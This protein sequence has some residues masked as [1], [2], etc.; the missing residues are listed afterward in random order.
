MYIIDGIAYAGEMEKPIKLVSVRPMEEY[1]LW[2]RFSND[3]I[4]MFDVKPLLKFPAFQR[5]MDK[6]I[7]NSVYI[8][9]GIPTWCDGEIDYCPDTLYSQSNPVNFTE[10]IEVQT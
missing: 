1:N 5:L 6:D 3:E 10:Q 8:D 2:L 4:R 7:F 9:S